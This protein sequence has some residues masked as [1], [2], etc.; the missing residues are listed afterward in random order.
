M[1]KREELGLTQH[2]YGPITYGGTHLAGHAEALVVL[3]CS[4]ALQAKYQLLNASPVYYDGHDEGLYREG[5]YVYLS[6]H[7]WMNTS[8]QISRMDVFPTP[9]AALKA[10]IKYRNK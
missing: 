2:Q 1:S 8:G 7:S 10:L 5:W 6:E 3:G 9:E 4:L